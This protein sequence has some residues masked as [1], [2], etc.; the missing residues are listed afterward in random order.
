MM[1]KR[2]KPKKLGEE[3][4]FMCNLVREYAAMVE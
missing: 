2:G 3:P 4:A 1:I